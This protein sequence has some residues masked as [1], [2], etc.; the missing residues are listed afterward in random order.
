M[1]ISGY[2]DQPN[3]AYTV[4]SPEFLPRPIVEPKSNWRAGALQAPNPLRDRWQKARRARD[5][6][7]TA[8]AQGIHHLGP[9][10]SMPAIFDELKTAGIESEWVFDFARAINLVGRICWVRGGAVVRPKRRTDQQKRKR[11]QARQKRGFGH[12]RNGQGC[13]HHSETNITR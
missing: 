9:T 6:R 5:D 10:R 4:R 12:R 7:R 13:W 11:Q 3:P 2:R 1:A 8:V